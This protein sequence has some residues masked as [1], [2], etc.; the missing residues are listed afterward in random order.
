VVRT[1]AALVPIFRVAA[2]IMTTVSTAAVAV[3]LIA[4]WGISSGDTWSRVAC[5][6]SRFRYSEK[7]RLTAAF[8]PAVQLNV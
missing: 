2:Q 5:H 4:H 3:S 7:M 8:A 6:M 1:T